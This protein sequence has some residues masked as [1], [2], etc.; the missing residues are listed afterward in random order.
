MT[1]QIEKVIP[2]GTKRFGSLSDNAPGVV[3]LIRP[4]E[5]SMLMTNISTV[6]TVFDS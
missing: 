2:E 3:L 4:T 5:A 1:P 6:E